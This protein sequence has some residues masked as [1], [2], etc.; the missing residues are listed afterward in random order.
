MGKLDECLS[1]SGC[2]CRACQTSLCL[3]MSTMIPVFLRPL[4]WELWTQKLKSHLMRTQSLKAFPLKPG[5]GHY[6]T[7]HATLT[8]WDF[9]LA[10]FY[11]SGP[12]TCIFPKSLVR[13][14]S[15]LAMANTG[16]SVGPQNKTVTLLGAGSHFVCLQNMNRFQNMCCCFSGLAFRNCG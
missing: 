6:I 5:V 7:M 14:F 13:F 4:S 2:G 10:N 8:A 12:F 11:P 3:A 9:L 16:S 1:F 15:V